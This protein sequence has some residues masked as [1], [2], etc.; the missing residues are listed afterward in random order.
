MKKPDYLYGINP[1]IAALSA[2]RRDFQRLYLNI[3][4]KSERK[5]NDK[6]NQIIEMA[7]KSKIKTKYLTRQKL[8]KFCNGRIHQNVVLKCEKIDYES[9]RSMRDIVA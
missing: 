6:I 2:E 3:S 1:I 7:N 9:V 4:E 8:S 5:S